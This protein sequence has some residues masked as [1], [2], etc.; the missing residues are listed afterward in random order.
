M[1]NDSYLESLWKRTAIPLAMFFFGA[2]IFLVISA[3]AFVL[4]D[5]NAL[6]TDTFKFCL[7]AV[8]FIAGLY[9]VLRL[10][11]AAIVFLTASGD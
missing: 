1:S 5:Y 2:L 10:I 3:V 11:K 8:P 9:V 7:I 6:S 4:G